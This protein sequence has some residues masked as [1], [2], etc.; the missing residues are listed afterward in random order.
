[1][2]YS[3][4]PGEVEWIVQNHNGIDEMENTEMHI[5]KYTSI[6]TC[7]GHNGHSRIISIE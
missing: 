6:R 7:Q 2:T 4:L 1:M 5:M 3:V